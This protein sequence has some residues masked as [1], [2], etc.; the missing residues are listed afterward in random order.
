MIL[1]KEMIM[2]FGFVTVIGGVAMALIVS[3]FHGSVGGI[4]LDV[5]VNAHLVVDN[6]IVLDYTVYN[7]GTTEISSVDIIV[8]CFGG[9][10]K[11]G[12]LRPGESVSVSPDDTEYLKHDPAKC[13]GLPPSGGDAIIVKFE[14]TDSLGNSDAFTKNVILRG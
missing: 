7:T 5:H 14:A 2:V 4:V 11:V 12:K 6:V 13:P 3:D 8:N 9:D 10:V 1:T